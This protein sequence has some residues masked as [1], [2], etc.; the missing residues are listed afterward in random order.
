M[1]WGPVAAP[2]RTLAMAVLPLEFDAGGLRAGDVV[3][4]QRPLLGGL[5][6]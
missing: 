5:A 3:L 6:R 2:L 1:S 4:R